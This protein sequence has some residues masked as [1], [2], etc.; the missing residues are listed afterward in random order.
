MCNPL[1][2]PY[3]ILSLIVLLS[4][5]VIKERNIQV[6]RATIVP[7]GLTSLKSN[8][9]TSDSTPNLRLGDELNVASEESSLDRDTSKPTPTHSSH[10]RRHNFDWATSST[11][12]VRN[13]LGIDHQ[14]ASVS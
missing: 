1:I 10:D 5:P 3:I 8:D 9:A 13:Q 14:L 12:Q 11:Q 2:L 6:A 7:I 4:F